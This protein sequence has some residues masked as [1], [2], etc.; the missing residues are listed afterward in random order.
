MPVTPHIKKLRT[1]CATIYFAGIVLGHLDQKQTVLTQA[2]HHKK[3][4]HAQPITAICTRTSNTSNTA[5]ANTA[6]YSNLQV[7]LVVVPVYH[8]DANRHQFWAML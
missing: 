1:T 3:H 4:K 2:T 7:T 8:P 5:H 6:Y